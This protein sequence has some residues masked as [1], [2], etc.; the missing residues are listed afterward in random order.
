ML[1]YVHAFQQRHARLEG[2]RRDVLGQLDAHGGWRDKTGGGDPLPRLTA[3]VSVVPCRPAGTKPSQDCLG[4]R[5]AV[6]RSRSRR[7]ND[8]R[9]TRLRRWVAVAERAQF[10]VPPLY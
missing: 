8:D 7:I 10:V 5:V 2:A 9:K 1:G 4:H 6:E 3:N